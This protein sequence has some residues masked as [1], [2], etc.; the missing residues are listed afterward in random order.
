MDETNEQEN[1]TKKI[2]VVS[3]AHEQRK[4]TQFMNLQGG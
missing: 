3:H 4:I 2:H 1:K